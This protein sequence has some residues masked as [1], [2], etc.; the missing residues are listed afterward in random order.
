MIKAKPIRRKKC[1]N[2]KES[3]KPARNFQS[4]CSP[5]CA[6]KI[7]KTKQA[8][9]KAQEATKERAQH[10]K[11]KEAVKTKAQHAKEAQAAVN[12]YVRLRDANLGCVSCDKPASWGGQWHASHYR[13][14]GAAQHLR[15]NLLN[16]HKSCSVCNNHLSGNI[17]FYRPELVRRIGVDRVEML[18]ASNGRAEFT[19]EYLSRIKRVF[20]KKAKILERRLRCNAA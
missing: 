6:V 2:C 1:A 18:E 14:R 7:S 3:F 20:S 12:R 9:K 15:F 17:M 5:D 10:A 11:A 4:W 8:L 19:V 16:I 13:S